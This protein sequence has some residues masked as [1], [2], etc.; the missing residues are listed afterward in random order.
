MTGSK[1][2]DKK[3]CSAGVTQFRVEFVGGHIYSVVQ[4]VIE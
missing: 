2:T 1:F 4:S 3:L